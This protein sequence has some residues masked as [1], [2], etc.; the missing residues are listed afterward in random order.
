MEAYR[1]LTIYDVGAGQGHVAEALR[2]RGHEIIAIDISERDG[3]RLVFIANGVTEP[4]EAGSVVMLCRPCH[5]W[6][7]EA[8]VKQAARC[9]AAHV[10]YVGK[11]KNRRA[12]L[13]RYSRLFRVV[14]G[15]VAGQ[16]GESMA[17]WN[18][19]EK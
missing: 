17:V 1:G 12:D 8:V 16:A 3:A 2:A 6:F 13:G 11:P 19:R 9:R 10:L 18:R 7:A 4:Y 5:G 15:L 14:K